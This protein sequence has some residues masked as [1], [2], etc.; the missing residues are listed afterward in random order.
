MQGDQWVRVKARVGMLRSSV[1][2]FLNF[3]C[4]RSV[5]SPHGERMVVTKS[6]PL[7]YSKP[8]S[9]RLRVK[10]AQASEEKGLSA[11]TCGAPS[12]LTSLR[13]GTR[14][15][16]LLFDIFWEFWQNLRILL[17]E[18]KCVIVM[19]KSM[20]PLLLSETCA[21][22][23]IKKCFCPKACSSVPS[24]HFGVRK[25][26]GDPCLQSDFVTASPNNGLH[27]RDILT[28]RNDN[29]RGLCYFYFSMRQKRKLR[30]FF[31]F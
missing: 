19:R 17:V 25:Q 24:C 3:S 28:L 2:S 23:W 10:L 1:W 26:A 11:Y 16:W 15:V 30:F 14:S 22:S 21:C 4:F 13:N 7:T 31:F 27:Q 18:G 9:R 8:S 5:R 12:I 29:L 20:S 6:L